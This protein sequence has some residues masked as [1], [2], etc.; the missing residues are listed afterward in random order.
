MLQVDIHAIWEFIL[1]DQALSEIIT[2]I[3]SLVA[4]LLALS[5]LL[6]KSSSGQWLPCRVKSNSKYLCEVWFLKYGVVWISV[7]VTII[8]FELYKSFDRI[9][10]VVVLGALSSPL[11][12]QPFLWPSLTGDEKVALLDRYSFKANLWIGIFGFIGNY[13]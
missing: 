3:S 10:Y 11:Y 7:M 1:A 6:S 5:M 8:V 2:V 4:L 13:W 12:L 9:H